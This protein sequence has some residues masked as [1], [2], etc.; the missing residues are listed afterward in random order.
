MFKCTVCQKLHQTRKDYCDCGNDTFEE[1]AETASPVLQNANVI[2][3]LM[4]GVIFASCILLSGYVVFFTG[5]KEAKHTPKPV[6]QQVREQT[7]KIP[8]IDSIWD[9]SLPSSAAVPSGGSEIQNYKQAL[10]HTL[11]SNLETKNIEGNGECEIEF[12]ISRDGKLTNKKMYKKDG[13][14]IFN[15][16]VLNMLKKTSEYKTPPSDY[17][18]EKIKAYIYTD[19][20]QI[21]LFIK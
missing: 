7:V 11:Y 9:N 12:L 16:I 19:N 13:D 14:K 15:T 5:P 20:G 6:S 21:K 3:N 10:Q 4:S 2:P 18:G 8:D 17:T 1:I